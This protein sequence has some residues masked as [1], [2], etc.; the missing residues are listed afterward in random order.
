MRRKTPA[1]R[2][3]AQYLADL[4]RRLASLPDDRRRPIVDEVARHIAEGRSALD[5]E[6]PVA[7]QALLERVGDPPAIATEAGA[8]DFGSR[9]GRWVARLVPWLLLLGGLIFG[10]GWLVGVVLLWASPIWRARDKLLGT[11]VCCRSRRHPHTHCGGGCTDPDRCARR[12]SATPERGRQV[13]AGELVSASPTPA[14]HTVSPNTVARAP[15]RGT[16]RRTRG[17]P[18]QPPWEPPPGES[19]RQGRQ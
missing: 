10:V 5:H 4:D 2:L 18:F 13:G 15:R 1:D 9:P 8:Y 19:L 16:Y 7:I 11:L 12:A 17:S 14:T 6:D 3:V